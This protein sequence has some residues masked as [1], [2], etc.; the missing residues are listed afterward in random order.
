VCENVC[1]EGSVIVLDSDLIVEASVLETRLGPLHVIHIEENQV[2]FSCPHALRPGDE[3]VELKGK[4]SDIHEAFIAEWQKRWDCHRHL[5]DDHW[6]ELLSLTRHLL[7]A[8][9]M[10]IQ[11]ITLDR[12]EGSHP[13]QE[14]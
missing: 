13:C 1:V 10:Q 14:E 11:P 2:W 5:P 6:D 4:L 7:T 8:D 3:L 12:W 9:T